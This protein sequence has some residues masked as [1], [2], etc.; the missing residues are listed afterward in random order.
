MDTA[1][2]SL[3]APAGSITHAPQD[4]RPRT[5]AFTMIDLPEGPTPWTRADLGET[6]AAGDSYV[7]VNY[8]T[9]TARDRSSSRAR[10]S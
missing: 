8:S 7:G 3:S 4:P 9:F 10:S 5:R 2:T 6:R 1:L